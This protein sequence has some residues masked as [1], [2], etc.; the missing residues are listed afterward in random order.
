[1]RSLS[2]GSPKAGGAEDSSPLVL[3]SSSRDGTA[4]AWIAGES[5]SSTQVGDGGCWTEGPVFG[6]QHDGFVNAV[7]YIPRATADA[8]SGYLATAGQDSLIQI[9]PLSPATFA[10]A[11]TTSTEPTF[12]DQPLPNAAE[13]QKGDTTMQGTEQEG[14]V[15][16]SHTLIGHTGNICALHTTENGSRLVSGSWDKTAKIWSTTT[17]SLLHTLTGHE[18][19]V[20]AVLALEGPTC[21][22]I[23]GSADNLIKLWHDDKVVTTFKGHTQAVR[24][25]AK[26]GAGVGAGNLFASAGNDATIR[27]WTL[28]GEAVTV[29]HGH[30]SFVYSLSAIL[31]SAGGG[32]ISGG[33]DRTVRVWRAADGECT[34]TIV[35]PAVSV[36]TVKALANGDIA[37][38]SSD[39]IVRVFTREDSRVTDLATLTNYDT[40][41]SMT[42]LNPSQV[43][44]VKKDSLP[45]AE[46][47]TRLVARR[48][49]SSW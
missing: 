2:S 7:E 36:W 35:I 23:T 21:R 34:Q 37:A 44:D 30:D 10:P 3:F 24:A 13:S 26:L 38:G 11:K 4:R 28:E 5:G 41:V 1:M 9:W 32:L 19:A 20:W 31:D 29:L 49:R 17:F 16:T 48:D 42:A 46:A 6:G 22:T 45:G 8:T 33:E 15:R 14:E 18:Q 40:E 47:L 39:G 25:L 27:L 12:S 43:G